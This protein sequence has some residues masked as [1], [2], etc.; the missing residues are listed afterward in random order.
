MW[1]RHTP[2]QNRGGS[3]DRNDNYRHLVTHMHSA[4]MFA[5][6]SPVQ[7]ERSRWKPAVPN[8]FKGASVEC[9][10]E[11]FSLIDQCDGNE[12]N[13]I[14]PNL[15][16]DS[17]YCEIRPAINTSSMRRRPLR[18]GII[19]SGGP[20]PGGHNVIAGIY[21]YLRRIH[22]ESR[23]FGFIG[24]MDGAFNNKHKVVTAE[25][26]DRYRNTGGFDMLW[27]G[28]GRVNGNEDLEKLLSVSKTLE[29]NGIVVVGGDGS[30]SNAALIADYMKNHNGPAVVGVPKTIDGDLR[31]AAIETTFGFDTAS[32]TYAELIGNL[33]TD[34]ATS[35]HCYHFVR[36]MGRSASHLVME[37]AM[38]TRPNMCLI[39]EE[40]E[41]K[42][43]SLKDITNDIVSMIIKRGEAYKKFGI[44]L[45][46]EGLIEF[47]PEISMLIKELNVLVSNNSPSPNTLKDS[48]DLNPLKKLIRNGLTSESKAVWD[49]LP[50]TIQE[51]LISDREA[52]GYIQV[53]KIATERLF[54]MLVQRELK[55]QGRDD[56]MLSFMPHY[57]GYEGRCAMPSNFDANYCYTLGMTAAALVQHNKSGYMAIVRELA[58]S[59]SNWIPA[60]CPIVRM[61]KMYT[62]IDGSRYPGIQK[63]LVDLQGALFRVFAECRSHWELR[64][65]YQTPG[66]IQF[67]GPTADSASHMVHVPLVEELIGEEAYEGKRKRLNFAKS[68]D[69]LSNL[70][71]ER[72]QFHPDIPDLCLD[73]K[74]RCRKGAQYV[75]KD[76]Y[77]LRQTLTY[78][79]S[80]CANHGFHLQEV[81]HDKYTP[82][83]SPGLRIG[84]VS[85]S[86]Q[87]PGIMNV[88]W[89]LHDR[90]SL[91]GGTV[92]GFFGIHGLLNQRYIEVTEDDLSLYKNLGGMELLGRSLEHSMAE[93]ENLELCRGACM[94]LKLDGLVIV[95]SAHSLT[96]AS[97]LA[98]YLLQKDC[99]TCVIGIPATGTNNV[100]HDLLE[101]CLGFDSTT[102]VYASLIG[103][104]LTDAAS[105]PKY[106]HFIRLMGR[107]PS[108]EVM[109]CAL[110][111]HPNF[112]LIAEEYGAAD[113]TLVHI[114][115]DICDVICA[116]AEDGKN[117]GTV[118]IP[119]GLLGHLPNMK[120]LVIEINHAVEDA[121][122]RGKLGNLEN[123]LV[124]IEEGDNENSEWC[125]MLTPWSLALFKTFP[126]FIRREFLAFDNTELKFTHIETEELLAQM[127][128]KELESRRNHGRFSGKFQAVTHYFGYQGR[129]SL[130]SVFDCQLG[131]THG[132][133]AAIIVESGLTGYC[134]T[135]RGLCGD[136]QAWK[137]GAI[138]LTSMMKVVNVQ[139][140]FITPTAA[141]VSKSDRPVIPSM[142]VQLDKKAFR[143]LKSALADWSRNDQ[144]CNPGP[145][146]FIGRA[147]L[148]YNRVLHEEQAEYLQMLR[149]VEGYTHILQRTCSFG[150]DEHFLKTAFSMLNSLLALR[151]HPE[152][153]ISHGFPIPEHLLRASLPN[154]TAGLNYVLTPSNSHPIINVN[155]DTNISNIPYI[156]SETPEDRYGNTQQSSRRYSTT[157]EAR[158]TALRSANATE[159]RAGGA[160]AARQQHAPHKEQIDQMLN[161][162]YVV[163]HGSG[164]PV[165]TPPPFM[166]L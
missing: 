138:P 128:K 49:F 4:D 164:F 43:M 109:E 132:Y 101:C 99:P 10:D 119:E 54:I 120:N 159:R 139:D 61:M 62:A 25:L 89:G 70:Q 47:V 96:E 33:C 83:V 15:F 22:P 77:T 50:E 116:R 53:A 7:L 92:L 16:K 73:P 24:G 91:V 162:P 81:V 85:L 19:L 8:C 58:L 63:T 129:S 134:T 157:M 76:P 158:K 36:V 88:L 136:A 80:E 27:S 151:L 149:L 32:K 90:M 163:A 122:S 44:V 111:T 87:A 84:V 143:W 126:K 34:V 108:F 5:S 21:D 123:C 55:R 106:W 14:L 26:M 118:I 127:V 125:K 124:N 112:V 67:S 107:D 30:N 20:A 98:E 166:S 94:D 18:V 3:P 2:S 150:V 144:F 31:N 41:E 82:P 114:V 38:H 79:P 74:A 93:A 23:L 46:P 152:D 37:C 56:L 68:F 97:I 69:M 145:I 17:H 147:S 12:L 52:T 78:Y 9:F 155:S 131:L 57:F 115:M 72:I 140:V 39:G 65:V 51:Q 13:S 165:M 142:E 135:V 11:D 160:A 86:R 71:K 153:L 48:V 102:K 105:M 121:A 29:L 141:L 161:S 75:P 156:N 66:P 6:A 104:V 42:R 103:N 117:F 113:K 64:D 137:L 59:P 1:R 110:Q 148:S 133:L 28:R 40:V 45:I 60:G 154:S 100:G 146:Q 95:G 35:G 130:P